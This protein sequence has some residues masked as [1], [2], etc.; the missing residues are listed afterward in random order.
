MR[1]LAIAVLL[2]ACGDQ[3][4][5]PGDLEIDPELGRDDR[6]T[7]VKIR[8]R[9]IAALPELHRNDVARVRELTV[10]LGDRTLDAVLSGQNELASVVPPGLDSGPY[11]LEIV[12]A[13]GQRA[14]L[15]K[16]FCV[17]SPGAQVATLEVVAPPTATS[18]EAF[19][20]RLIAR[21]ADGAI[22]ERFDGGA[23]LSGIADEFAG[24]FDRGVWS[25]VLTANV[26][27]ATAIR[28]EIDLSKDPA[29][30]CVQW[31]RGESP[32]RVVGTPAIA[33]VDVVLEPTLAQV[34]VLG[35]EMFAV[36]DD[37]N[38]PNVGSGTS[39]DP[40]CRIN[41]ALGRQSILVR[42]GSYSENLVIDTDVHL[43]AETGAMLDG[44]GGTPTIWIRNNAQVEIVRLTVSSQNSNAIQVESTAR[45]VITDSYVGPANTEGVRAIGD[46]EVIVEGTR[47]IGCNDGIVL[48]TVNRFA[49]TNSIIANNADD[50]IEVI[51]ASIMAVIANDTIV[52]NYDGVDCHLPTPIDST[53]SWGNSGSDLIPD[54]IPRW[55]DYGVGPVNG[56]TNISLD[57]LLDADFHLTVRSPC[58]DTGDPQNLFPQDIDGDVRPSGLGPDIGAD[59]FN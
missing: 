45:L 18:G 3:I 31:A 41:D 39:A 8:G 48:E 17:L 49:I 2:S 50:G 33:P 32:M 25:G 15:E 40:Y 52:G 46:S 34:E 30:D 10:S 9:F 35:S 13:L 1:A 58:I 6:E 47:V 44:S 36:V 4:P 51:N 11:V 24:P 27:G 5:T 56:P 22:V 28:A 12:D 57:P 38:C 26:T 59:E 43:V 7:P 21:D 16:A 55:S 29:G 54:C 23:I 42:A 20:V 53:I 37:D 19:D 14:R